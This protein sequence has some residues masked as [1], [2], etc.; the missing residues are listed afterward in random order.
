MALRGTFTK[1]NDDSSPRLNLKSANS[2]DKSVDNEKELTS[3]PL[4]SSQSSTGMRC[5]L[6]FD[7]ARRTIEVPFSAET[8][9]TPASVMEARRSAA[10][11]RTPE[12]FTSVAFETPVVQ[13]KLKKT[14]EV[15]RPQDD[16][17]CKALSSSVTVAVRVRPFMTRYVF[18]QF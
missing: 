10:E 1:V 18:E 9:Q 3:T 15:G 2:V 16:T 17:D 4:N 6:P 14:G 7:S 13:L 12:Y 5:R 11:F 8:E